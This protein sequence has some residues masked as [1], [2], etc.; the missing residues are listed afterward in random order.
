MIPA[1]DL[2]NQPNQLAASPGFR[3]LSEQSLAADLSPFRIKN[4]AFGL[5]LSGTATETIGLQTY[6]LQPYT[7]V[8]TF[9]GQ[10][11]NYS[12]ASPDFSFL[13][14]V[15]DEDF[16]ASP[17]LN[18]ELIESFGFFQSQGQPVFDLSAAT[19][20]VILGLLTKIKAECEHRCLDYQ[21]L[22]RI[23]LLELFILINREY[24]LVEG[25]D[26]TDAKEVQ[27]RGEQISRRFKEL[28]S[29]H[30]LDKK[31]V[32]QYADLLCITPRHL[33]RMVTNSTGRS[34]SYW[35]L[36][37]EILEAKY[38]LRFSTS[39]IGEIAQSLGYSDPAYFSKVFRKAAGCSPQ[40][41]RQA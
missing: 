22:V 14:C 9:P 32:Q 34:P 10:L 39:S 3:L 28:V 13:C 19:G 20:Q 4:Y 40:Q 12:D 17:Y 37:M 11:V 31:Q 8:F 23:Y 15:F 38:Q 24:R 29:R 33:T 5:A 30:F 26:A 6:A 16:T 2:I 25:A 36:T 18:R 41:Y 27:G 7:V 1:L 35:I 21:V